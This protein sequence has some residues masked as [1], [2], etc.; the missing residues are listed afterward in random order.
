MIGRAASN[1][2]DDEVTIRRAH[3]HDAAELACVYVRSWRQA[4]AKLL[5]ARVLDG[6]D[7]ARQTR[8]WR[9]DLAPRDPTRVFAACV[10][11]KI[12][13]FC[14]VGPNRA[15]RATHP[16]EL[17]VIYLL[18]G[19]QGAGLGRA[20]F[21]RGRA[22]LAQ[23]GLGRMLVWVLAGNPA[24]GFYGRMGGR[25]LAQRPI[26]MGGRALIEQAYGWDA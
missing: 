1:F 9:R 14:A 4:Y 7:V 21:E 15:R 2:R 12:V 22:D 23:R 6:L 26:K 20:L 11:E 19:H 13:G 16:G 25:F 18:A 3:A 17:Y 10:G 24:T 5:P 8:A